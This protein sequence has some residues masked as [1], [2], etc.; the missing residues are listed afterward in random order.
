MPTL[1]VANKLYSS[2]SLRPWLLMRQL[3]IAFNE[4]LIPLGHANTP[5][6]IREHSPAGKVPILKDGEITVWDSLAIMEYVAERWPEAG[7]WPL[8]REARA[9]ARSISAEMH[10]GFAALRSACPMNLGKRFA[11]RDR[12]DKVAQDASRVEAIWREAQSRFGRGGPFLFGAFSAADAMYAPVVTRLDT[13]GFE[14]SPE[15]RTYMD[16]VLGLP[17]FVEWREAALRESWTIAHDEVDEPALVD[18]R[19]QTG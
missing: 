1:L 17:A 18:F 5:L 10:S 8:E 13:Y 16:A 12:G 6:R 11:G 7:V 15:S 14:V 9:H 2:W 19:K 3:G 4:I